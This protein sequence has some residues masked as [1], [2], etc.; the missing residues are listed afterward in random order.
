LLLPCR[1]D[2]KDKEAA[3]AEFAAQ[4]DDQLKEQA[5]EEEEEAEAAALERAEREEHEQRCVAMV[6]GRVRCALQRVGG[7]GGRRGTR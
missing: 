3:F 6:I 4:L 1:P 7:G 2:K 5:A